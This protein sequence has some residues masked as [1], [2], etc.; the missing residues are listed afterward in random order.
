M[1]ILALNALYSCN[2]KGSRSGS[3]HMLLTFKLDLKLPVPRV[4]PL[5]AARD[6]R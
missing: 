4:G 6:P 2:K 5:A 1:D 3:H